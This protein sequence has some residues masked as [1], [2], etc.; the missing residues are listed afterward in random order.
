MDLL[1]GTG[2]VTALDIVQEIV[3]GLGGQSFFFLTPNRG[4]YPTVL[5][6][7]LGNIPKETFFLVLPLS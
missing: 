3:P 4:S 6:I 7:Y 2:V 5:F 1:V